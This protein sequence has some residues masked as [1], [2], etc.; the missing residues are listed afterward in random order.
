MNAYLPLAAVMLAG[1]AS[2]PVG[3]YPESALSACRLVAG[4]YNA[5]ER[6]GLRAAQGA[7]TGVAIN[8]ALKGAA[9]TF[10]RYVLPLSV[11]SFVLPATVYGLGNGILEAQEQKTRIV[12][13]CLR[14]QG[15]RVY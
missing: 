8:G 5:A 10:G 11:G 7:A 9:F 6:P 15:Y 1:C 2:N 3:Q 12:R 13:E 4:Q 14:D